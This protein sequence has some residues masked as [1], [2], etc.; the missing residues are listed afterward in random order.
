MANRALIEILEL[1]ESVQRDVAKLKEM[2]ILP[3]PN[4]VGDMV[5]ALDERDDDESDDDDD[6]DDEEDNL[7]QVRPPRRRKNKFNKNSRFFKK[8]HIE[9]DEIASVKMFVA[10]AWIHNTKM[11]CLA[12]SAYMD[13]LTWVKDRKEHALTSYKFYESLRRLMPVGIEFSYGP[14][15]KLYITFTGKIG[16]QEMYGI[17]E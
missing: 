3:R 1:L 15:N 9:N 10:S 16:R 2:V 12:Q 14:G 5:V 13:Y 17:A 11:Q 7:H 4:P 6:D 8:M